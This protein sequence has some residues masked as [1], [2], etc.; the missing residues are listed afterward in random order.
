MNFSIRDVDLTTAMA[1]STCRQKLI[2]KLMQNAYDLSASV[3]ICERYGEYLMPLFSWV[4]V[5]YSLIK[6]HNVNVIK[7]QFNKIKFELNSK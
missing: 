5:P 6:I 2:L 3:T 7:H 4:S 1:S